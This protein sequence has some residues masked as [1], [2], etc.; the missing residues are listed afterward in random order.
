MNYGWL[1]DLQSLRVM[2]KTSGNH[3]D[4]NA[5]AKVRINSMPKIMEAITGGSVRITLGGGRSREELMQEARAMVAA[6]TDGRLQHEWYAPDWD[7]D[8][9]TQSQSMHKSLQA[10]LIGVAIE[11]GDVEEFRLTNKMARHHAEHLLKQIDEFFYD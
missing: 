5:F 2:I 3:R 1:L 11:A 10:L 4:T 8:S 9:L 7:A 6:L